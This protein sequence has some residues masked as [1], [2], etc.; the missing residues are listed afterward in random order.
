MN[1]D[2][3]QPTAIVELNG[4]FFL[5]ED[6]EASQEILEPQFRVE[7]DIYLTAIEKDS[8]G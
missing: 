1:R 4:D 3:E 6:L 2:A 7:G 8:Q 5:K